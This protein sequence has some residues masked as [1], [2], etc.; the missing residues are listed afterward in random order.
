MLSSEN[1][2]I[3]VLQRAV[4]R[5]LGLESPLLDEMIGDLGAGVRG[6]HS[7]P[8]RVPART[9]PRPA[10]RLALLSPV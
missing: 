2:G 10:V 6:R 5:V 4:R 7:M 3:A 9:H 8:K 1:L